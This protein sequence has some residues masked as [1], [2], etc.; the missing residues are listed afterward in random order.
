MKFSFLSFQF[1]DNEPG[2]VSGSRSNFTQA[3]QTCCDTIPLFG[4]DIPG[5]IFSSFWVV[6]VGMDLMV[7]K[8]PSGF[9][10]GVDN[11]IVRRRVRCL[12]SLNCDEVH[13][14]RRYR[15]RFP[16][17]QR[18]WAVVLIMS[19][20]CRVAT[21]I[22]A[23]ILNEMGGRFGSFRFGGIFGRSRPIPYAIVASFESE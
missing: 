13:W 8:D 15:W 18:L 5:L 22:V 16:R 23:R 7:E 11:I 3:S 2:M 20:F 12:L 4:K 6:A 10:I 19:F 9:I 17:F 1:V 21:A 14:G